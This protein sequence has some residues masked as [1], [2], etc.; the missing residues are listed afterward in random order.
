MW[1]PAEAETAGATGGG[2][3]SGTY[4]EASYSPLGAESPTVTLEEIRAA[5]AFMDG[6]EGIEGYDSCVLKYVGWLRGSRDR[7]AYYGEPLEVRTDTLFWESGAGSLEYIYG[8]DAVW[9]M[10]VDP[11][12]GRDGD[13]WYGRVDVVGEHADLFHGVIIDDDEDSSNGYV[14]DAQAKRPLPVG[15]YRITTIVRLYETI[16]CPFNPPTI[17]G[18]GSHKV[19]KVAAPKGTVYEAFFD[20]DVIGFTSRGGKLSSAT[21][22]ANEKAATITA[23]KWEKGKVV[24]ET[25]PFHNLSGLHLHVISQDGTID[26]E[27]SGNSANQEEAS[28]RLSWDVPDAPWAHG[29]KLMLR[30]TSVALPNRSLEDSSSR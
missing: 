26:T 27:L 2:P 11:R 21:F 16:P 17:A 9:G 5:I 6:G 3:A 15:V 4:I 23:L 12:T 1:I 18:M 24:L 22:A 7:E 10:R 29:D 13:P 28:K 25:D 8:G 30:L 19:I 20:P 14:M